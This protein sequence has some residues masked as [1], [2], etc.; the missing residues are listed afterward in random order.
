MLTICSG[1][2]FALPEWGQILGFKSTSVSARAPIPVREIFVALLLSF[3]VQTL[4]GPACAQEV[5][6]QAQPDLPR[7]ERTGAHSRVGE[8]SLSPVSWQPHYRR[9]GVVDGVLAGSGIVAL[10]VSRAVGP[11][12][13]GPQGGLWFDD[14]VRNALRASS[15]SGR[16]FASDLSDVL[17]GLSVS[18]AIIGDP[19]INATWLRNSPDAGRELF[20]LNTEVLA[21]TLGVQQ[22]VASV[23]GRERPYGRTCGTSELS[24][25]TS[26]CEGK[27]RYRS[28]FSGHTSVPFALAAATCTH[29]LYLPLSG[30]TRNAWIACASGFLVAGTTG[31]MRIV[32]DYHYSTDVLAGALTGSAIGFGIPLLHY[33]TGVR[34][35]AA[36]VAGVHLQVAPMGAGLQIMGRM[37]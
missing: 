37:P 25:E 34:L 4:S 27:D 11:T 9:F 20:L 21:V 3:G 8:G 30:T 7:P 5:P 28:F 29:H 17:L 33:A 10:V 15:Y 16:L 6:R 35:P 14:G 32:A 22:T 23:V 36:Q 13:D 2:V 19:L 31:L 26:Q 24:E 1:L 18:Y 12:S